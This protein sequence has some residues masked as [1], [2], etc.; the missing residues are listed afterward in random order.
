MISSRRLANVIALTAL[1]G[2]LTATNAAFA[3]SAPLDADTSAEA[4]T[5]ASIA[6]PPT[7]PAAARATTP[8]TAHAAAPA[9]ARV[10]VPA[11]REVAPVT[12]RRLSPRPAPTGAVTRANPRARG[13]AP[14]APVRRR[15]SRRHRR[16]LD[17]AMEA[18]L[19][20]PETTQAAVVQPPAPSNEPQ[21]R[22]PGERD[23]ANAANPA[24]A[25]SGAHAT[26]AH[27]GTPLG[28]R[29]PRS[30]TL[31]AASS[32]GG[33]WKL[34]LGVGGLAVGI[35]IWKRRADAAS[36]SSSGPELKIVRRTPLQHH[37]ELLV[38]EVGGQRM[39]LGATSTSV[40]HLAT[41]EGAEESA[42]EPAASPAPVIEAPTA[43]LAPAV[44]APRDEATVRFE[45]MLA[46]A[47]S[48]ADRDTMRTPPRRPTLPR[49][50]PPVEEEVEEQVRGLI[51]L[52]VP[53]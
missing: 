31:A 53:R 36:A 39:L 4:S 28:V 12:G 49:E 42:T 17:Q 19:L 30:L 52:G 23:A 15:H 40:Q 5:P 10:V 13:V 43:S 1:V 38:V 11:G 24:P 41:L 21:A 8:A 25:A 46:A 45:A 44:S 20:T 51:S 22:Q 34:L 26:D 9:T 35:F 48:A 50:A 7:T 18:D 14:A 2:G 32:S 27:A 16:A 6:A 29:Q 37:G 47:R 33:D 3:Q